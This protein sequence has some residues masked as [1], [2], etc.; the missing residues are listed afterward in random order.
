MSVPVSETS[1]KNPN[2]SHSRL[3][4]KQNSS[5][6]EG[7]VPVQTRNERFASPVVTDFEQVTGREIQW[8]YT[9]LQKIS[10]LIADAVDAAHDEYS[11]SS[12]SA[13]V[14]TVG[15]DDPRIGRAGTPEDR[16]SASA[17]SN[18][19]AATVVTL[20]GDTHSMTTLTRGNLGSVPRASHTVVH[21]TANSRGVVVFENTGDAQLTENVE[22]VVDDHAELTVVTVQEWTETSVHL[23]SHFARLGRGA[24]LNYISV[25]LGGALVRVNPTAHLSGEGADVE[26]SGL[27]FADAGQYIEHQV[28]VAHDAPRTKSRV[29][30]KGALQ[31]EGAHTVWIG[32][33][34]ITQNAPG[35]DSYELNRNLLLTDGARADSVPNLEIET[36]DIQGAGHASTSG[37]FDDEQLFYLQSRGVPEAEARRLVVRGFLGEIVQRIG[38][39]E[40]ESRLNESI[41]QEL[42]AS[43]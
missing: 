15:R 6:G 21:A 17:W 39:P 20:T 9:P 29:A 13:S 23:A 34:M 27:Y 38:I 10:A 31:G 7:L 3:S 26:L 4:S 8:K 42:G 35:T 5:G 18:F 25:T 2:P 19:A 32:D 43:S 24:K 28:F 16:A 11:V 22:I 12:D 30:Y 41:E 33:V 1:E 40:L 37:R 14:E 36:G